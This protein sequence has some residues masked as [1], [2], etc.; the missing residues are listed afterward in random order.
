MPIN[1]LHFQRSISRNKLKQHTKYYTSF[2]ISWFLFIRLGMQNFS[3]T[4][5]AVS[6][7]VTLYKISR[8]LFWVYDS[9]AILKKAKKDATKIWSKWNLSLSLF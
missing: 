9:V 1:G 8:K 3:G 5:F 6:V 4:F 2:A 7:T